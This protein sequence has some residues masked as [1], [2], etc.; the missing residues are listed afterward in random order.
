LHPFCFVETLLRKSLLS[1][2]HFALQLSAKFRMRQA[3]MNCASDGLGSE[4]NGW[5]TLA[6][7]SL[8]GRG[9][10]VSAPTSK[11]LVDAQK[12]ETKAMKLHRL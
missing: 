2:A 8:S 7:C 12:T 11:H 9:F 5:I 10:A 4:R 6:F 3:L 1:S